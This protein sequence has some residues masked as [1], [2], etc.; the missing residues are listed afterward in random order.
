MSNY[1][2]DFISE[3]TYFEEGQPINF[4]FS[5]IDA[6]GASVTITAEGNQVLKE[7]VTD[8][9]QK[10]RVSFPAN[11]ESTQVEISVDYLTGQIDK[12]TLRFQA[13]DPTVYRSQQLINIGFKI[14]DINKLISVFTHSAWS[15]CLKRPMEEQERR[16]LLAF[17]TPSF[18]YCVELFQDEIPYLEIKLTNHS[19]ETHTVRTELKG[20]GVTAYS[21][22]GQIATEAGLILAKDL[23]HKST[24]N[25]VLA[26]AKD[27]CYSDSVKEA[28]VATFTLASPKPIIGMRRI[29]KTTDLFKNEESSI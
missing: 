2:K 10:F 23:S 1:I 25:V 12:K 24:L 22:L 5:V 4:M 26:L 11:K 6:E 18:E 21:L 3:G 7:D 29:V 20:W 19:G 28:L 16:E 27:P 13:V 8:Y 15:E 9:K 17:A 14:E